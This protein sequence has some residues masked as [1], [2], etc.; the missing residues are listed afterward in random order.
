[1]KHNA[2][3]GCSDADPIRQADNDNLN[4]TGLKEF[5]DSPAYYERRSKIGTRLGRSDWWI[6][7]GV[8]LVIVGVAFV[9]L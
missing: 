7:I 6:T 9:I 8:Y 3:N 5:K 4:Q 1:M 2:L